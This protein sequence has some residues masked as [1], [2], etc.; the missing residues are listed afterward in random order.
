MSV[1][2]ESIAT[3]R[4]SGHDHGNSEYEK[5][6][7]KRRRLAV[8]GLVTPGLIGLII[9]YVFPLVWM[10]RMAFNTGEPN[11][12][13]KQTFSVDMFTRALGNPYYWKVIGNTFL[14]GVTVAVVCTIISYPIALFLTRTNS[15]WKGL[16][17]AAAIAPLLT[18][19]VV[20]TY[21]WMVILGNQG[22]INELLHS[23]GVIAAPLPLTNNM[24]GV[25]VGLIEIFMPYAIL[26]MMSG[27]GRLNT[28]LEEAASS[29][30]ANKLRVFLKVTLPLSLPGVLAAMLLVFVLAISTFVTPQL[31]GGGTVHVLAT[32]VFDQTTGLLNW[33]FAAALSVI[34]LVLFGL[35]I[36]VYQWLTQRLGID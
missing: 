29:L 33:P 22:L 24:T 21:G 1:V 18:S 31:L 28:S 9:S 14:M 5:R 35:V 7:A 36:A 8:A 19:A 20:R 10:I 32:E 12:V 17:V 30:G 27:F 4:I 23:R 2:T 34:L 25:T 3:G 26:A 15:R 11:G 13:I 16:L 6:T